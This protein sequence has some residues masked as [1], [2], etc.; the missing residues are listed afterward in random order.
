MISIIIPV[1][2][3]ERY[4][5]Q[6]MDSVCGQTYLD[7]EIIAVN[8]GS[9][10]N[11]AAILEEYQ[12]RDSRI[13]VIHQKNTGLSG[14][15]N[16]GLAI[17]RG[18]Y[19]V[20]LDSDDWMD[21]D[22]CEKA[23]AFGEETHA[24]IVMWSFLREYGT[25]AKITNILGTEPRVF[26]AGQAE[27][28]YRRIVGPVG[29]ELQRPQQIDRLSTAWGKLYR[30]DIIADTMFVDTKIIGT[31]DCLF[32]VQVFSRAETVAYLPD[33]MNHY[34]K[35]N[36]SS[37]TTGFDPKLA[38]KWAENYRRIKAHLTQSGASS[39]FF[40]ALSNRICCGLIGF[41][42]RLGDGLSYTDKKRE[43]N[44][45]LK[46]DHYREALAQLD[47]SGMPSYWKLFF[48]SAKHRQTG[49]VVMLLSIMRKL[50]KLSA[51]Q[52]GG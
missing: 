27:H 26:R 17:A 50:S 2:N 35:D 11:S 23:V 42:L 36:V 44:R 32:N 47:T 7:L 5:R 37:L 19:I 29:E 1:Y 30:R 28:L 41:C 38:D 46:M 21:I 8:D 4:L 6:C 14:A 22:T 40:R 39:V 31:E 43:L 15:R 34:R 10:D 9:P 33:A 48:F 12:T 45:V 13:R 3:T 18:E 52:S 20:F 24:D 49:A 16:A 51:K 25:C